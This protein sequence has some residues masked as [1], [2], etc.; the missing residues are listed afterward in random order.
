[1]PSPRE[2]EPPPTGADRAGFFRSLGGPAPLPGAGA[3]GDLH[4]G[5]AIGP[6]VLVRFLARGGMGQVWEAWD[7]RLRRSVALKLVAPERVAQADLERFAR[8]ARAG[9]RLNHPALVTTLAS[10]ND[11]GR[12]WIAQELIG[13]GWTL[14]D[15][16]EALRAAERTPEDHYRRVATLVAELAEGLEAAHSV[17]V[18][19]R[20]I[21]PQNIL[22]T[23]DD[24]PKLTDFGLARVA[25]DSF[26]SE[27]G[28][29]A[30][31]FA[32]M[33]PE[34][35][36]GRATLDPRSDVFSLGVVLY[37]LLTLRRPFEGDTTQQLALQILTSAP[38]E[39]AR[40]RSQCPRDLSVICGKALEKSPAQRYASAAACAADLRRFLAREPI[41][42]RPPG[43][44]ARAWHQ[45]R[46][47]PVASTALA[48]GAVALALVS[49]L[50]ADNLATNRRLEQANRRLAQQTELAESRGRESERGALLAAEQA[51][52]AEVRLEDVLALAAQRDLEQL[53]AEAEAL[54]PVRI[55]LIPRYEAWLERA[56]ALRD[57]RQADP[58]GDKP[59]RRSLVDLAANLDQ[60]RSRSVPETDPLAL[61][62]ARR[63]PRAGELRDAKAERQWKAR[64]LGLEPWPER[65][66]VRAELEREGLPASHEE[67][68]SRAWACVDPRTPRFGRE[69]R[70]LILA[71][72]AIERGQH[73]LFPGLYDTLAWARFRTGDVAGA[74]E[75][76]AWYGGEPQGDVFK[77]SIEMLRRQAADWQ[78]AQRSAREAEVELAADL[79]VSLELETGL[80]RLRDPADAWWH[81]ELSHLV[82]G[83]QQLFD[84]R[85]GLAGPGIHPQLGWGIERRLASARDLESRARAESA[86]SRAWA[87]VQAVLDADPRFA[88]LRLERQPDLLPLGPDPSSGLLEFAHLPSGRPP[89]RG[90]DARLEVADDTSLVL[91][92]LPGG[93]YWMGCQSSDPGGR[94]YDPLAERDEGPVHEVELSPCL[95]SKYELTQGQ[96]VRLTGSNPSYHQV[97]RGI[98]GVTHPVEQVSWT[99]ALRRLG[100][101]G[102]TLP[103]ES[104]WEYAIRAGTQTVWWT[105]AA[106]ESLAGAANLADASAAR[107]GATWDVLSEWPEFEDGFPYHAAVGSLRANPFGLHD[108]EGNLHELCLDGRAIDAYTVAKGRDPW[109]AFEGRPDRVLRGSS[110]TRGA[111]DA[112][113]ARRGNLTAEA[114]DR[115]VGVRAVRRLP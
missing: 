110:F 58:L 7:D 4:P 25:G 75:L 61:E 2:P 79:L 9:G 3:V 47:R 111:A 80:R 87:Q 50:L 107:Q 100:H 48:S 18:I 20:D 22:I 43:P 114:R 77:V 68:R 35:V 102:L 70:G 97:R 29:W 90:T 1:M 83:I 64:M 113:S 41:L 96:W 69:V 66:E 13:D 12:G 109:I 55:E 31:T 56:R 51:R 53:A 42:A 74:L 10:G 19:H 32:Y 40:L 33:S 103:L 108:L 44:A 26:L 101:A 62:L 65:A 94:N 85:S 15:Y 106:R 57:G 81:S 115:A 112:C 30:G 72:L 93:R 105:G 14:K 92:L 28:Q 78:E 23:A 6:F 8:E 16:I 24:R 39:P 49:V 21:K 84:P 36:S 99:E 76:A 52:L 54:W 98:V 34:Q 86:D 88:G 11:G 17:G 82:A 38:P 37:E 73:D 104:Q 46:R 45:A 60:L 71:E 95:F 27:S 59:A 89:A 63:H 91:V 67:L 5:D